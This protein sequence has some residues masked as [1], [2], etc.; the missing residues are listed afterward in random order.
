MDMALEKQLLIDEISSY[1]V[2][3]EGKGLEM[4]L[5]PELEKLAVRD[6]REILRR[7][8]DLAR[9]PS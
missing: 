1:K 9:T 7:V 2:I 6:L 5:P 4:T 3:C 8:K